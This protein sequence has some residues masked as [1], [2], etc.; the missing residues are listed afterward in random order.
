MRKS[1][2]YT[3]CISSIFFLFIGIPKVAYAFPLDAN[4]TI[5]SQRA[6]PNGDEQVFTKKDNL[7]YIK[8][9]KLSDGNWTLE[10]SQ[11]LTLHKSGLITQNTANKTDPNLSKALE[12]KLKA[13]GIN[14]GA[15]PSSVDYSSSPY[16]PPVGTQTVNDCAAW[17]A[18]YYL[19][20]YQEAKDLGW[21]VKSN[22]LPIN[23]HIFSPSFIYN[24]INGGQDN[25][26]AFE[27][28]GNL[29]E[30][31]GA[32]SL[33][34]F[35]IN[36]GDYLTQ[37]SASVIKLAYPHRIKQWRY[38]FS[39]TDSSSFKV[40][41]TKEYLNT[42]DLP[43]IGVNAGYNYE[44]PEFYNGKS[45]ITYDR[46]YIGA[47]GLAVVGYDDTI[48]TPDG[49]GAFKIVNSWGTNWGD[50]GFAY[51]TYQEFMKSAIEGF[52]F[53]DLVNGRTVDTIDSTAISAK[54]LSSTQ[55]QYSWNAPLNATGYKIFDDS[56]NLIGNVNST[57]YT[58]TFPQANG[59]Y[60]RYLEA[61]N[62]Y[63]A[64]DPVKFTV[65]LTNAPTV[66]TSPLN[67]KIQNVVQFNVQFIGSGNYSLS[68]FDQNGN[69][70]DT[71][72]NL[73]T[74]GGMTSVVWPGTDASGNPV[75]DGQYTM[76]VTASQNGQDQTIYSQAFTKKAESL[77]ATAEVNRVN[78]VIQSVVV[79]LTPGSNGS[80]TIDVNNNG[81]KTV[82]A[83]NQALTAGQT[84][85]YTIPQSVYNFNNV[86]LTKATIELNVQ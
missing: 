6:L 4:E 32:A 78:G 38:L 66:N 21:D 70:V 22:G 52:V 53:T 25:G 8:Q 33:A 50:N 2:V 84:I 56:F 49:Q 43:I 63:S 69:N 27:D 46:S 26:S 39:S 40:E 20:T 82:I 19:R 17:S 5:L 45:F 44:Y 60:T 9:F 12:V 59:V 18:G 10:N 7:T 61:Y 85:D 35:S 58:E 24:Q 74:S 16:L 62:S 42:G 36:E 31:E 15:L 81:V 51:I 11:E 65:D 77:T 83:N 76:K 68:I 67:V 3:L 57:Q 23:A 1:L 47:H 75:N 80:A 13:S 54:A 48:Q 73:R 37:P 29:L 86:D 30:N 71:M 55:A 64:D 79:H 34:D 72:S 41:Q 28:V 14:V